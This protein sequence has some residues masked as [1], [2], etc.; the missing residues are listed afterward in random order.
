MAN[1][2]KYAEPLLQTTTGGRKRGPAVDV[3]GDDG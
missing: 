1:F 2:L 3:V